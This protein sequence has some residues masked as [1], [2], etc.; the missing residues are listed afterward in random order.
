MIPAILPKKAS[1]ETCTACNHACVY[2]PVSQFPAD[3]Q[4]MDIRFFTHLMDELVSLGRKM[5]R[6][7]F[8]HYNE[9][10][11]DPYL[12]ERVSLALRYEFF[13]KILLNTNLSILS[14]DLPRN[15]GFA[16]DRLEFNIN[17]PTTDPDRYRQL[18][19]RDHYQRVERNIQRLHEAGFALRI[20]F[21]SNKFTTPTEREGVIER[22]GGLAPVDTIYSGSRGGLVNVQIPE[23]LEKE[24][25][26]LAGCAQN[27]PVDYVH[28]GIHGEVFLCCQDFF[29]EF[30][31]GDL[32]QQ[33]LVDILNSEP[34]KTYLEYIYS[35]RESAPN[36][37]CKRCE[38]AIYS[39]EGEVYREL[40][41]GDLLAR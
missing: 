36:F 33:H 7:S 11:I 13:Q 32:T 25:G 21:Q 28:I 40:P 10:L 20:N 26:A 12:V 34:A 22:F 31:L 35:G 1:I 16:R 17:L 4:V 41:C 3:Q 37:I 6:I 18:H 9:P 30:R 29:K 19:G 23:D 5:K 27:R 24:P 39:P 38:F 14:E 15:L 2:C 8:N